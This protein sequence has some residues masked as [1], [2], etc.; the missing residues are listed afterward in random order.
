M[1]DGIYH[2]LTHV[3]VTYLFV[4]LNILAGF[5]SW[6]VGAMVIVH[7]QLYNCDTLIL[8][9]SVWELIPGPVLGSQRLITKF[10]RERSLLVG[11][12]RYQ[13]MHQPGMEDE[14][15]CERYGERLYG[16]LYGKHHLLLPVCPHRV[17]C[18]SPL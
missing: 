15:L 17:K 1:C 14:R 2:F 16:R 6:S 3:P 4:L 18:F 9:P 12:N 10:V 7:F 13:G 5:T 11:N 8:Q